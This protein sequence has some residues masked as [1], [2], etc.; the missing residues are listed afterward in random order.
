[1]KTM[2]FADLG[3][4]L[5]RG[6]SA[7]VVIRHAERPPLDPGDPTFGA[8][9][10]LTACGRAQASA[11][12]LM[13]ANCRG[14]VPCMIFTSAMKRCRETATLVRRELIGNCRGVTVAEFLGSASPYFGDVSERLALANAGNYRESLNDYFRTG[15]QRGFLHIKDATRRFE[16]FVWNQFCGTDKIKLMVFVTH[17][18]NVASYLAGTGTVPTFEDATWPGFMDAVVSVREL[19]GTPR[20]GYMRT[21]GPIPEA[22]SQQG[23]LI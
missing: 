12:G 19:D 10:S 6:E 11:F 3:A 14:K 1:M 13:L 2:T 8:E 9:L 17:D 4:A 16:D 7:A 20:H 22:D 23:I 21:F 5:D 15:N 18:L